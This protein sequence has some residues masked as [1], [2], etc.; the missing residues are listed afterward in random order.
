MSAPQRPADS[1]SL[2]ENRK[3]QNRLSQRRK[4]AKNTQEFMAIFLVAWRL[5]DFARDFFTNSQFF[6]VAPMA[7][8]IRSTVGTSVTSPRAC[9]RMLMASDFV[10]FPSMAASR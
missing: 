8:A 5:C 1:T 9:K 10:R 3:N 7:L 2:A 4:G 6:L